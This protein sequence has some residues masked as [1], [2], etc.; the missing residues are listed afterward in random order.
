MITFKG[1]YNTA[2]VMI[3]NIEDELKEQLQS[4]LNHPAFEHGYIAVMPDCHA[5]KGICIGFTKQSNQYIIPNV[6]GVDIHCS[7]ESYNLGKVSMTDSFFESLENYIRTNIPD[8]FHVRNKPS[9]EF[10]S[11]AQPYKDQIIG[12]AEK[13]GVDVNRVILG[14]GSLGGGNHFIEL[15]IDPDSNVWLTIHTGSRNFG[16]T[17]C[18]YYQDK[19]KKL[20]HEM[21]IGDIY[22]GLEF[23]PINYGGTEYLNS[24][25][26][27]QSYA[28]LNRKSIANTII[29]F[30]HAQP[31]EIIKCAHNYINFNDN[32]IRKGAIS[33]HKG[34]KVLIPLN[35]RDGVIVGEG[36]GNP[37]WNF[38]APHGAG[39]VLSRKKAKNTLS[40]EKMKEDMQG[41]WSKSICKSTLDESPEVYKDSNQIVNAIE[42]SVDIHF[43][44]KPI[45]NLKS[46]EEED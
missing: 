34:E 27:A 1:K 37:K 16:K 25:K 8:G 26:I 30:F 19:A 14:I 22:K 5:G 40:L 21:F 17:I 46:I 41:I 4:I 11:L 15:N 33:A 9:S 35:M 13:I 10:L 2:N 12:L 38:S 44:M 39:R 7:I 6:I 32:I 45:F 20:M 43:I 3:D 29:D 28:E 24:M 36:K 42:E 31:I 23:L 18:E